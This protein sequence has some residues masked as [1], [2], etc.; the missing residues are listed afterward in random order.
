MHE[1]KMGEEMEQNTAEVSLEAG[2]L[3][4]QMET[5]ASE[6]AK[7]ERQLLERELEVEVLKQVYMHKAFST[8]QR[9]EHVG[10]A[11]QKG[12]SFRRACRLLSVARSTLAYRGRLEDRDA[13]LRAKLLEL[14]AT[15]PDFGYRRATALLRA[16]GMR[17]NPKRVYRIWRAAGLCKGRQRTRGSVEA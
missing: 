14:S 3:A 2:S 7:F 8:K 17:V 1:T 6:N 15:N 13:P 9:K 10:F 16:E 11:N 12:L 5:L 4:Q